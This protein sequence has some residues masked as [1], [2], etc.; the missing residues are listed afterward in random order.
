MIKVWRSQGLI[1]TQNCSGTTYEFMNV[2]IGVLSACITHKLLMIYMCLGSSTL[3]LHVCYVR[4]LM[5]V[6]CM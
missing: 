5:V 2:T 3:V 1:P 6:K 4:L